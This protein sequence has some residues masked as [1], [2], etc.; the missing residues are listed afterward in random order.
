MTVRK[1]GKSSVRIATRRG[2]ITVKKTKKPKE[3]ASADIDVLLVDMASRQNRSTNPSSN[4]DSETLGNVLTTSITDNKDAKKSGKRKK[5]ISTTRATK[6]K[7]KSRNQDQFH[8]QGFSELNIPLDR[9]ANANDVV[10]DCAMPQLTEADFEGIEE[11]GLQN[12]GSCA[13]GLSRFI[14]HVMDQAH[15]SWTMLFLDPY[16]GNYEFG[17]TDGANSKSRK[18][19]QLTTNHRGYECTTP[20]LPSTKKYCT[21]KGPK[22]LAWNCT[23]DSQ[24]RSFR[25]RA[26][27]IGAL[28]VFRDRADTTFIDDNRQD[29]NHSGEQ[30]FCYLLPLGPTGCTSEAIGFSRMATWCSLPFDCDVSLADRWNALKYLLCS[31]G[32]TKFVTYHAQVQLLP[33]YYH[34]MHDE[35]DF[36][37]DRSNR[38]QFRK[39]NFFSS[40][41]IPSEPILSAIWDLK[42]VSWML[43]ADATDAELE[44]DAF[45]EGFAHLVPRDEIFQQ[46]HSA[47]L[48]SQGLMVAK[49]D[50]EFLYKIY[51]VI[52]KQLIEKQLL[53]ALECIESPVQSIL[54]AMECRGVSFFPHRLQNIEKK[55]HTRILQLEFKCRSIVDDPEF[56]L[57]SP[58]QVSHYIFDV[59]KLEVPHGLVSKTKAGSSHRSTSEEALKAIKSESINRTGSSPEIIDMILEFRAVNKLLTTYVRGLPKFCRRERIEGASKKLPARIFPQWMQTVART[60]RLSC[61]KPNLQQV[62]N[63]GMF[64]MHPREAFVPSAKI[65]GN[66]LVLFA[67]DYS[68]KEVRI[69][70]HMS[71]DE[72]LLSLFQKDKVD[73]YKQMSSLIRNKPVEEVTADE[74]SIFKQVTLAILYGMSPNQ[75]G[76]KLSISKTMAEQMMNDFFLRF[77]GVKEWIDQTKEFAR[78]NHF[79][80]TISG[81]RRYLDGINSNDNSIRRQAERQAINTVIQGSSADVMKIAMINMKK[82]LMEWKESKTSIRPRILLQIH[83]ELLLELML[84]TNDIKRLQS[85]ALKS[86]CDECQSYFGLRV[87]LIVKC[88]CG[89]SWGKMKEI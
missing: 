75:V 61:R 33:F 46:N 72:A 50:L 16:T 85:I 27:L 51:P 7:K 19:R 36:T 76:K 80:L 78:R 2:R 64:G 69:L 65:N 71:R 5:S 84:N 62:P 53:S 57:S 52:N 23:C 47:P 58:Q 21:E 54:C 6:T 24:I 79:V 34:L 88:S 73:I 43:R 56:L 48:L 45:R 67:C 11:M 55:L 37:L 35:S 18:K 10:D 26:M 30:T 49:N 25:G 39:D 44:F 42:I 87:P 59:L 86:C 4:T 66:E 1:R 41:V 15:V 32:G 9:L 63:V 14:R 68:Q 31:T 28:F 20:L 89:L 38:N 8:Q 40:T 13:E 81:R 17:I 83:D 29:E 60:G 3:G 74:R 82:N 70:A 77:R 22:C 12:A